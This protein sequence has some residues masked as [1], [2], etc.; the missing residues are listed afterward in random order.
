MVINMFSIFTVF[1]NLFSNLPQLF[2]RIP[3]ILLA[4]CIHETAHG[5]MAN[6]LGDH[7]ARNLGRLTLNPLKHLDPIGTVCMFLFG[8]GWAKPVPIQS[9]NFKNPKR[10]FALTAAAGPVSNLIL[11]FIG[12]FCANLFWFIL[13]KTGMIFEM[14]DAVYINSTSTFVANLVQYTQM[15]F[16]LF[17]WM[18]V[19]LAVFNLLPIPPL[20]G[21]RIWYTF[22]PADLYFKVMQYEQVI[23]IILMMALWFGMLDRP[24]G[25]I[26]NLVMSGMEWLVGLIPFF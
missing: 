8:F 1:Q 2:L 15:F 7:T 11:G 18:N 19:S 5:W 20:D 14:N 24:L 17:Y 26:V 4:L 9:R 21:S 10:D 3:V 16:N 13:Q 23:Q 6:K 25:M 12:L 22:L